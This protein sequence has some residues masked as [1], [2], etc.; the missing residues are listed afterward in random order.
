MEENKELKKGK[1]VKNKLINLL[2]LT[3]LS[4]TFIGCN[5][6]PKCSDELTIKTLESILEPN[7]INR[8]FKY[9]FDKSSVRTVD[10][11][12]K[13]GMYTCKVEATIQTDDE[14]LKNYLNG[15][16]QHFTY[17]VSVTDDKKNF[18]VELIK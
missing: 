11:N 18:Y 9:I 7:N 12:S 17:T 14:N 3:T 1:I 10:E 4:I 5:S 2:F 15:R 13:I 16:K 8:K 6:T